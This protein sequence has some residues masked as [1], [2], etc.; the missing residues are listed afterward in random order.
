MLLSP[1]IKKEK[2]CTFSF[3]ASG[4][5]SWSRLSRRDSH[6]DN[7]NFIIRAKIL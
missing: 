7:D 4:N 5:N 1:R 3:Q 2:V 6:A